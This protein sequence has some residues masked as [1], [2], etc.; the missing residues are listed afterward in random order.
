MGNVGGVD[1]HGGFLLIIAIS[2]TVIVR[3]VRRRNRG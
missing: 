2:V 3:T 1:M